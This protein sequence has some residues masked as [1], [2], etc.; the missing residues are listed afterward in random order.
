MHHWGVHRDPLAKHCCRVKF[1]KHKH[2]S[3]IHSVVRH[4]EAA[5]SNKEAAEKFLGECREFVNAGD[6]LPQQVLSCDETDIFGIKLPS[7]YN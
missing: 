1:E 2:R 6:Y 7:T 4:G 5:S 3:V